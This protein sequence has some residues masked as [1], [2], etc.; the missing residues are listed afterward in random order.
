MGRG[1]FW[2]CPTGGKLLTY[3][4]LPETPVSFINETRQ[5]IPVISQVSPDEK[6]QKYL[7]HAAQCYL[8]GLDLACIFVCRSALE[9]CLKSSLTILGFPE[10]E[11]DIDGNY[12]AGKV[13]KAAIKEKL[14]TD[15][16][17]REMTW[18]INDAAKKAIHNEH[19][20]HI[21]DL[22]FNTLF[23]LSRVLS[24]VLSGLD[25]LRKDEA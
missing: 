7:V 19:P 11:E 24:H 25:I 16:N 22:A 9:I 1:L 20:E 6:V 5:L 18:A 21:D 17:I 14:I 3:S 13:I 12:T 10:Y 8:A 4:H 15:Q 2:K 23:S